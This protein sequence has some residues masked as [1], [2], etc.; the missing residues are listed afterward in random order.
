MTS[1][2]SP[3]AR[4]LPWLWLALAFVVGLVAMG[5]IAYLLTNIQTHKNEAVEYPAQDRQDRSQ[6]ARPGRVGPEFPT[7]VRLVQEDR[8]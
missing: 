5:G 2:E 8:D 3:K 1:S 4:R 6:R 7:R